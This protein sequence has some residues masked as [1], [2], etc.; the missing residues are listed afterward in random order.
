MRLEEV[1]YEIPP[2][3]KNL[4]TI[5][6]SKQIHSIESFLNGETKCSLKIKTR[7]GKIVQNKS[8]NFFTEEEISQIKNYFELNDIFNI[9]IEHSFKN[10]NFVYDNKLTNQIAQLLNIP[11]PDRHKYDYT[12]FWLHHVINKINELI[13]ISDEINDL[14]VNCLNADSLEINKYKYQLQNLIQLINSQKESSLVPVIRPTVKGAYSDYQIIIT[15]LPFWHFSSNLVPPKTMLPEEKWIVY[16]SQ[17]KIMGSL[18]ENLDLQLDLF[19]RIYSTFNK[20]TVNELDYN[21][22]ESVDF[23]IENLGLK[24]SDGTGY[25]IISELLKTKPTHGSED[26]ENWIIEFWNNLKNI[27][28][29]YLKTPQYHNAV[30]MFQ[31]FNK[32][33]HGKQEFFYPILD[34]KIITDFIEAIN[35]EILSK[36]K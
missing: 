5:V 22:I 16:R 6:E 32:V 17:L 7:E 29:N 34:E 24:P 1:S 31:K 21:S 10:D 14:T 19:H 3:E 30:K 2:I 12:E 27:L 23:T 20:L 4:H 28:K 9:I 36:D 18:L 33:E 25:L 26:L 11:F 8:K 35:D 15:N 13:G